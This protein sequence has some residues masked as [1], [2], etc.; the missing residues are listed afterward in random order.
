[1]KITGFRT[2]LVD[3]HRANYIFGRRGVWISP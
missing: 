2:F 1:M 3:A